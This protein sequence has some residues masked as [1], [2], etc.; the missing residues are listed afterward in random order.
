[1]LALTVVLQ[2]WVRVSRDVLEAHVVRGTTITR[3]QTLS[4]ASV[5]LALSHLLLIRRGLRL[6]DLLVLA[7]NS[8]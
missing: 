3:L 2:H 1:M 4:T 7:Q 8:E 5:G 6:M